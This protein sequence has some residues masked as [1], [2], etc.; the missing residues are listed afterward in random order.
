VFVLFAVF[1]LAISTWAVHIPSVQERTGV[2]AGTLGSML[3]L[4]GAGALLGMQACG[5]LINRWGGARVALVGSAAMSS[6]LALPLTAP[7]TVSLA[8]GLAVFG[9]ATG[10]TDVAMNARAVTVEQEAGRPIM[11]AFHAMFSVGSVVGSLIGAATLAAGWGMPLTTAVMCGSCL[12]SLVAVTPNLIAVRAEPTAISTAEP[13]RPVNPRRP[14]PPSR[15]R[16]LVL[17][18]ALAFLLLLV[19]GSAMDW[20]SLHA[21]EHLGVSKAFGAL[22]FAAF[23]TAMTVGRFAADRVTAS[24]GPVWV[25]RYGGALAAVGL[26]IV[27]ASPALALTVTGW[28]VFGLGLSGTL[29]QVFSA[30]GNVAGAT[31]TD[32][33]RVVGCGYAALLAGPAVIGWLS[34]LVTLNLALLLPM[35]AAGVAALGAGAVAGNDSRRGTAPPLAESPDPEP[36][37]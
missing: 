6:T 31:G 16:R 17:L 9:V 10:I 33:S 1:G 37:A 7:S 26:A 35:A 22:A 34:E 12:L 29:P 28:V 14:A 8:L 20:S 4:H 23:V 19:E 5:P 21:Q 18:G 36:T 13:D 3:L 11:S 25:V 15:R 32:F 30:A 24:K 27:I 2:S